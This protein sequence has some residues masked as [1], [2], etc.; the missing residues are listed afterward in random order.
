MKMILGELINI[1]IKILKLD[2]N[3]FKNDKN[4]GQASIYFALVIIILGAII[5]IIPNGS[6]LNYMSD[7]FSLG[8]IKGPSLKVIIFTAALVWL[9]KSAYL[10]FIGVVLFP[11]KKTKCN[12]RKILILV[13]FSKV[14]LLLNFIII[15]PVLLFLSTSNLYADITNEKIKRFYESIVS[16]HSIVPLEARTANSLGV[17]RE[18]NGVAID[19]NHILTIGYIVLEAETIEIGLS[20]GRRL[21]AKMVAYDHTSG[22]GIIKSVFPFPCRL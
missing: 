3:F 7:N 13:A 9:I 11:E 6:F 20:D 2:K 12:F 14:P 16:I 17:E 8:I 19:E 4:F 5:S 10:F 18:G 21:P 15:N 1:C 22:F